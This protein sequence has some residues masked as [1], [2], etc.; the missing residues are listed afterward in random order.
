MQRFDCANDRKP[1]KV[2][3]AQGLFGYTSYDAVQFFDTVKSV[4]NT[5]AQSTGYSPD[6]LP[7][8]PIRH[9]FN[10]FKDELFICEN[11]ITVIESEL[12]GCGIIDPE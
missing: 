1:K 3:F 5:N 4:T 12:A 2:R 9:R 8:L 7:A 10:H 11:Q 6:A